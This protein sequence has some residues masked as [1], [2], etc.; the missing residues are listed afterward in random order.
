MV[1]L[2]VVAPGQVGGLERVV[3][4]LA[5]GQVTAGH[6]V[7]VAVVLHGHEGE[8][9]PFVQALE[10]RGVEVVPV[11]VGARAY[12]KERRAID[13]ICRRLAPDV[14]H[15]HG[16]RP[17]VVDAGVARR[18]DIPTVSTAHGFTG[19]GWKNRMYE[20]LQRRA[21]RRFDAVVAVSQPLGVA[22]AKAGVPE[23]VLRVIPNAWDSAVQF[24]DRPL[25]RRELG[26]PEGGVRIG[27]AGRISAEK[28]PDVVL[29]AL[30]LLRNGAA[31]V[32]LSMLGDGGAR[33]RLLARAQSLGLQQR[34]TWHGTV[35]EAAR[36]FRAFDV[37]VLSSRTEGT[38]IVLF[39]AMAAGVPI[40]AA[41]VGGVP[42]VVSES[43]AW[44]VPP[45]DPRAL[46]E[47]VRR[48]L[49]D[50][51]AKARAD[52][53]RRRL[54]REFSLRPWLDKYESLYRSL[55]G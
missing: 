16:Y 3:R 46:A 34:V 30:A 52:A 26:V 9:H 44:L 24:L 17:D 14:V 50:A 54:E 20:R 38:P 4:A 2:H 31:P 47:A 18:R 43:E 36:Y 33:S 39:E 23:T 55:R 13:A 7:H 27:W 10:G 49:D 35:P 6:R 19:G 5:G 25:A 21:W 15:T 51:H 22:L 37:F 41:A 53:A 8:R 45:D 28:G 1:I 48:V 40:V 42:G 29:D 32:A 11:V 12:R